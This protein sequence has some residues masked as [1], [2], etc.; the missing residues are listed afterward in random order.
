[1]NRLIYAALPLL[2]AVGSCALTTP[3]Q[4]EATQPHASGQFSNANIKG[5]YVMAATLK[6]YVKFG[7][8]QVGSGKLHFDGQG[9]VLGQVTSFGVLAD[10]KGTYEVDPDGTGTI[11]YTMTTESGQAT[12]GQTRLRIVNS[13]EIEFQGSASRD[14]ESAATATQSG[15]NAMQGTLRRTAE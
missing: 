7:G 4:S 14:W 12:N 13:D 9:K 6:P 15:N 11:R 10:L 8:P 2:L 1:M 3:E 5:S